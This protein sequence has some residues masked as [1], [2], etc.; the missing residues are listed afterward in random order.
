MDTLKSNRPFEKEGF[1]ANRMVQPD[2]FRL[3]QRNT[4]HKWVSPK[5]FFAGSKNNTRTQKPSPQHHSISGP[6]KLPSFKM[7][8]ASMNMKLTQRSLEG[9]SIDSSEEGNIKLPS[10]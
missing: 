3:E 9:H 5:Q 6:D 8:E 1:N 2:L 4:K 7:T 10:I